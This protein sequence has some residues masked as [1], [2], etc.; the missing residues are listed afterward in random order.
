MAQGAR[1]SNGA[2]M[3]KPP[4]HAPDRQTEAARQAMVESQLMPMGV[5]DPLVV[6]AFATVP[7]EAFVLPHRR[8][9]AHVD[10]P[11]PVGAGRMMMSP[12]SLGLLL[13]AARPRPGE[14]ALV[15]GAGTG[16]AAAI[17]A[18]I[19]CEVVALEEVPELAA[20]ARERL[21]TAAEVV[22]GPLVEGW[23]ARAPYH[24]V[25]LDGSVDFVPDAIAAQIEEGG[26]LAAV[27]RGE[28]GVERPSI[29]RRVAGILH[30]EPVAEAGAPPLPG[31]RRA[32]RF[33]FA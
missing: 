30:L 13:Q 9:L 22:E 32:P 25:L 21:G 12:L 3:I 27:V 24:L 14:R 19:G 23:A 17:L 5:V 7:R 26:R 16:Y 18:R 31:F 28:D 33:A 6:A 2:A 29:G 10:A 20:A 11:Q 4:P 8:A 15:V 1:F